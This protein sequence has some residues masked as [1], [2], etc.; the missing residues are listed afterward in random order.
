MHIA[1]YRGFFERKQGNEKYEVKLIIDID[2][3]YTS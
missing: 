3:I 1:R 2:S